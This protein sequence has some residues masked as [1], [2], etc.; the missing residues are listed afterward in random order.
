MQTPA[1]KLKKKINYPAKRSIDPLNFKQNP[2]E[3]LL[4]TSSQ[5]IK[6]QFIAFSNKN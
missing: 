3:I 6:L 4:K 5:R 1:Q 2:R